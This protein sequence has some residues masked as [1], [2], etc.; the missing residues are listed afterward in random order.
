MKILVTVASL[1]L[2]GCATRSHPWWVPPP[3]VD[4][5][6][7]DHYLWERYHSSSYC[8]AYNL[9]LEHSPQK[10]APVLLDSLRLHDDPSHRLETIAAV[11]EFCELVQKRVPDELMR[12]LEFGA[13]DTDKRIKALSLST[14]DWAKGQRGAEQSVG[15]D[16]RKAADG[17]TGA[18]QR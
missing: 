15:G 8:A 1:A 6:A 12:V 16:S 3:G 9:L 7:L 2:A 18:P 5:Q 13:G 10:A 14:I 17:L 4:G 11:R